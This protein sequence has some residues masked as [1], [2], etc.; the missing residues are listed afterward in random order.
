MF[1]TLKKIIKVFFLIII[2]IYVC[3]H[4]SVFIGAGKFDDSELL[5]KR[6]KIRKE[7]NGYYTLVQ[8]IGY[9]ETRDKNENISLPKIGKISEKEM[10]RLKKHFEP[11]YKVIEK[12]LEYP[13]IIIPEADI[14]YDA[15]RV[16]YLM[17][18]RVARYSLIRA[19][20]YFEHE[21]SDRAMKHLKFAAKLAHTLQN[22]CGGMIPL[23]IGSHIQDAMAVTINKMLHDGLISGEDSK[24]LIGIMTEYSTPEHAW[25]HT[26][27]NE[28]LGYKNICNAP[29]IIENKSKLMKWS[30]IR[31]HNKLLK[32][33]YE[34]L[35][36]AVQLENQTPVTLKPWH[37]LCKQWAIDSTSWK[38]FVKLVF[39]GQGEDEYSLRSCENLSAVERGFRKHMYR[40][41]Q[42]RLVQGELALLSY[43]S[44]RGAFPDSLKELVPDYIDS[45]PE[46]PFDKK[47]IRY[48]ADKK[49]LYS[50]GFDAEDNGGA[51]NVYVFDKPKEKDDELYQNHTDIVLRLKD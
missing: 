47:Q 28:Y 32:Q 35:V 3:V 8:A 36:I 45:V 12:A 25:E 27:R 33:I 6:P 19:W 34:A 21:N 4:L 46:D 15:K 26:I 9:I 13:H 51:T 31:R 48:D 41:A 22:A 24:E 30:L 49:I 40:K 50:M 7:E 5:P 17:V 44:E 38:A 18:H 2:A 14:E 20:Y 42:W 16:D 23:M 43:Y 11:H 1:K 29:D 10:K 39:V 37:D